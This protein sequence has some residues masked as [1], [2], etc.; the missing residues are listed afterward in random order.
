MA[1]RTEL[2]VGIDGF[3]NEPYYDWND[4][5]NVEHM[6]RAIEKVRGELGRT[7]P[8]IV[9]GEEIHE[10]DTKDSVNPAD[11]SQV[12]G[13]F[14]QATRPLADRAVESAHEFFESEWKS[15]PVEERAEILFRAADIMR[16]RKAEL[17][18]W[19][20]FEVSKSW[21][22]AVADVAELIDFCDYYAR[23]MLE[24]AGEQEV[25]DYPGEDNELRYIPLGV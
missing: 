13:T 16:D 5:D 19:M 3:S 1:T 14:V 17:A 20:V 21:S 11:P 4:P 6:E 2:P 15:T 12:V 25:V 23:K 7:Y 18:A 22:E 24:L 10:G 9:D 8:L